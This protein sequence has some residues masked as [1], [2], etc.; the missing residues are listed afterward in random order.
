LNAV[1]SPTYT[2]QVRGGP[3]KTD[4]IISDEEIIFPRTTAIDFFLCLSQN[5]YKQFAYNL[6]PDCIMLVDPNLVLK[7]EEEKYKVYR[8]PIIELTKR[9][10]GRMIFT[11]AVSLGAMFELTHCVSEE[12]MLGAI[13]KKVPKGTEEVNVRAF[14]VGRNAVEKLMK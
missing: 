1:Q 4:V 6:K 7:V 8:I 14:T 2:A 3:T 13:Q 12:S 5:S 9:E 10:M 11:S